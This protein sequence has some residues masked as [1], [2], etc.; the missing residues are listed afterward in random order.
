MRIVNIKYMQ[1]YKY[2]ARKGEKMN[3]VFPL[4]EKAQI[5]LPIYPITVGVNHVQTD[6]YRPNG[7]NLHHFLYVSEGEGFFNFNGER[8]VL[9]EGTAVFIRKDFPVDYGRVG[10][11]FNTSWV[12]FDGIGV[13][14]ILEYFG[15][16]NYALLYDGSVGD[17]IADFYKLCEKNVSA[18]KYAEYESGYDNV[19]INY[20]A[21]GTNQSNGF[22]KCSV[23]QGEFG[24]CFGPEL[25][26]AE[27]LHYRFT[28]ELFFIIKYAW[29][30]TNLFEQWLSP[31]SEGDTGELYR[32]FVA[33]V[34]ASVDYLVSKHYDVEI[35][36]TCWMQGESDSFSVENG[37]NY[38]THLSNFIKDT[39]KEFSSRAA[40]DGIAFVDATIADN[41]MFWVYCD[42]V[43]EGKVAV[44]EESHLNV[45]IDTNAEGLICT[46]EP[47]PT[48]DIPHYDS[49]SEI[50]LGWLFA[51]NLAQFI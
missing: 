42:L 24:T 23:R 48:P 38:K 41:P 26:L 28:D 49:L 44:A 15:A 10:K 50:K 22:V 32:H 4:N 47:Q 12:T 29:G 7:A 27:R 36:G 35:V 11:V 30:G 13:D 18:E 6:V 17:I 8:T 21:S 9:R 3:T 1:K 14:G 51:D 46:E 20:F 37:N 31:S 39:R 33:Y 34:N 45:L 43:N 5:S 2:P 40:A 16:E 25:G 19:Y